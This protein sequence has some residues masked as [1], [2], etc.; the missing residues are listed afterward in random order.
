[1]LSM[2]RQVS[3]LPLDL[4][5][6]QYAA[7]LG[8]PLH[9]LESIEEQVALFEELSNTEQLQLLRSTLQQ[10]PEMPALIEALTVAY[11]DRDLAA[12][13][14]LTDA[15]LAI[16]DVQFNRRF[17]KRLI[18]DRNVKML[19]RMQARR[20]EGGAFIAVGAMHLPGK[21]GLLNLLRGQGYE[22]RV[23]Y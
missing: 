7:G 4:Y 2:P 19:Q 21:R 8:K 9:G 12:M 22:L 11:L 6:Q 3:G 18:D 1:V 5:L 17:I 13:Q 10:L 20:R 15:Q 14:A 16:G 23:V